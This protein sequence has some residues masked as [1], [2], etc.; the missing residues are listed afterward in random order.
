VPITPTYPGVYIEEIPSGI[1]NITPVATSITAFVGRA[2]IGPVDQVLTC[3]SFG[4]FTR[5]YGGLSL[6]Y[7]MSY[8]V[9]DFFNNGGS[10]A[11]VAR[12]YEPLSGQGSGV[13]QLPFPVSPPMLPEG[14]MLSHLATAGAT[15]LTLSAPTG[16]SEGEPV[17]GMQFRVGSA[18][19]PLYTIMNFIAA[20]TAKNKP[21]SMTFFPALAGAP[22]QVYPI[23]TK[24]F[25]QPGPSPAGWVISGQ[26][27]QQLT[28]TQ[29]FGIPDLGDV[30]TV[31]NSPASYTITQE[32]TVTLT[33]AG[34]LQVA[35]PFSPK[36]TGAL[37]PGTPI[38]VSPPQI[39]P[40]PIGWQ[41]S[42]ITPGATGKPSALAVLNGTGAPLI[43]DQFTV[44]KNSTVY[45]VTGFSAS[46]PKSLAQLFFVVAGSGPLPTDPTAFCFCCPLNFT[47][48]APIGFAI[49]K[50]PKIGANQFTIGNNGGEASGVIDIGYTFEVQN[51]ATVYSVRLY[52]QTSGLISFLPDAV[53]AFTGEIVFSPP[54]QLVAASPGE[55]G[56]TLKAAVDTS[57]ITD[58]TAKQFT[59]FDLQ[60][61][62]LFNLTLQWVDARNR[63][64]ASE[65]FL[66]LAVKNTG[67]SKS[68][69]NRLDR[70]LASQ[71]SLA[72]VGVL[73]LSP[74]GSGSAA[75][76]SG[77]NDGD[78][79]SPTTY[80]GN[81]AQQSGLY[82]F[83]QTPLFNLM[84]IPPD[85][86]LFDEVP[87]AE[88][89]L[90]SAVRQA[91]AEYCTDR[92]AMYIVDPPAIWDDL[93]AQGK[94]SSLSPEDL[95][96]S[97]ENAAGIEVARNAAVYFPRLI[98]EDLLLKSQLCTFA[99]CGTIAGVISATDVGRGV[100]K[101]PAG[102]DA[103]LAG[104]SGF[105]SSLTD[106]QNGVLNQLGIN[107]LRNF[108][109]I[110]PVVWG[111][112]TLRG[113][114]QFEDDY[115]YIPVRRLTLYIEDS[116]YRGTQWAVFEPNDEALWS[117]LRL[118]VTSFLADLA[119]QGA[120]YNYAVTCDASTTTPTDIA[121]GKVN[122]LVQI[123]PVKPAEFVMIQI[124][125]TAATSAS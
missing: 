85:R 114:D 61:E 6:D 44:G 96:I 35:F 88:Q 90:D 82:M 32:P 45:T 93:V 18:T 9:Q 103:G 119:R 49:A 7:P 66:N 26:G 62:D 38:T 58:S 1:Q 47:R 70:V 67:L 123:A 16:G 22:G 112:R 76:G 65:R 122:I 53:T 14:W 50:P 80:I 40:M 106:G 27:Q 121:N 72:R 74:P 91:A 63:V 59:S 33:P 46:T 48:P 86:R 68:F 2:P 3:L 10:Y 25:F 101:A 118:S 102:I 8:A 99:P 56:N 98:K 41:I 81:Q 109:V 57:G 125:Q 4:D 115:K 30:F 24:L 23:C 94:I 71:S 31:G 113:A 51:D 77:G 29:G 79:L 108:P 55:W 17:I 12:L 60:T 75:I 73:P 110:G 84:C 100:W 95:G 15:S 42:S 97:G 120:F 117:T 36:P 11:V 83:E 19:G 34:L 5:F 78:Y 28:V 92:L 54:L 39:S 64:L 107:C 89:D 105:T 43:G 21:A 116:L 69:P 87:L 13:A 124:Q 52:D 111:A 104:V 37:P 20:D